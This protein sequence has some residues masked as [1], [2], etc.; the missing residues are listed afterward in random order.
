M[1]FETLLWKLR[2][3]LN[4][5]VRNG[6]LTERGLA[7]LVGLSQSHT[8]NVLKGARILSPYVADKILSGLGM[9][10]LDL[11]ED[12]GADTPGGD[13]EAAAPRPAV[14]RP[15]RRDS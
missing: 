10:V 1:Y 8:H 15:R 6:R 9:T 2:D 14:R 3:R 13:E 5:E 4:R 11:L 12:D 7:R